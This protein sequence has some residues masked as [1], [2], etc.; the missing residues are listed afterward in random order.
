MSTVFLIKEPKN[1]EIIKKL[2]LSLICFSMVLS[3]CSTASYNLENYNK[4]DDVVIPSICVN[5]DNEC[6]PFLNLS[7]IDNILNSGVSDRYYSNFNDSVNDLIIDFDINGNEGFD[8]INSLRNSS[9]NY[10]VRILDRVSNIDMG[11][12]VEE[13]KSA[14]VFKMSYQDEQVLG[15]KFN[16]GTKDY[17]DFK[18]TFSRSRALTE[19]FDL[20]I[21]LHEIFHFDKNIKGEIVPS[22]HEFFS[23]VTAV[24]TISIKNN[25]SYQTF[26]DI[27]RE[28]RDARKVDAEKRRSY[29]HYGMNQWRD[30]LSVL[31]NEEEYN[32]I[33][34]IHQENEKAL[35]Q[36]FINKNKN[37]NGVFEFER[38]HLNSR[39][40]VKNLISNIIYKNMNRKELINKR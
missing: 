18:A 33:K 13:M 16:K 6:R 27:S 37:S 36:S 4:K 17:E 14:H 7:T 25:Y 26:L 28:L 8:I 9:N 32:A 29:T 10:S 11:K 5:V 20:F 21:A 38:T 34:L 3:G 19:N 35:V 1:K 2:R 12:S 31:P 24:T 40:N 30:L 23:D 15:I 22:T 39:E